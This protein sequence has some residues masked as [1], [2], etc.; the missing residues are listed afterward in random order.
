[1]KIAIIG[2]GYV[3]LVTGACMS[4]YGFDVWCVD[5]DASKIEALRLGVVPI[6]EPSLSELVISNSEAGRLNFTTDTAAAVA[7]AQAVF[8]AV[9]TPPAAEGD[10]PDVSAVHDAAADI[11]R[12]LDGYTV[13]VT[14]STVP[15]GT[16]RRVEAI[17]RDV[18]PAAD[19]DCVS[20]PEFLREG[21]A[22]ADFMR[23]DRVVIGAESE[24]A[25]TLMRRLYRPLYLI[26]CPIDEMGLETAELTKYASNAFLATK[27][28][29]I[30]QVADLCEAV[31]GD[32]QQ[33][34]RSMGR[35]GRI[36][37]K[38]LHASPGFGGSCFPKDTRAL[39][40][41]G[42]LHGAR[43]E[44]VEAVIRI[45]TE[46]KQAMARRIVAACGG[47]VRG[48]TIAILGLSFKPNTD[49]LR[50][51]P[52]LDIIA[53]L[54]GLGAVVRAY[55]P[56]GMDNAR[57]LFDDGLVLC[58]SAY[59]AAE[60]AEAVVIVTEWNQFRSLDLARLGRAVRRRVF[61]DLRN[62]YA[63]DEVAAAGFA[64]HSIGRTSR[65]AVPAPA[66]TAVETD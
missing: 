39:A 47:T 18:N 36:G 2:T 52:A 15:I 9:G 50:D 1:M 35:D 46:R 43:Q 45:N 31:D 30:N 4:E 54:R 66:S 22:V 32:I 42:R 34:A 55:D 6:Y 20:N 24:R 64:Y 56:A 40:A 41:I 33:V 16:S 25:I 58:R 8:I 19:F 60:E 63:P 59:E 5:N 11:G 38:F 27:I 37:A 62:V 3:G 44:L 65:A 51:S 57:K 49:D 12:S 28:T 61:V 13:V 29:F 21:S 48:R 17:I 7:G 53:A 26:G 23:P 10:E 14:K